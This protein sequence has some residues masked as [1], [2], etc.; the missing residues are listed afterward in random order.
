[1]SKMP[2]STRDYLRIVFRRKWWLVVFS[3]L[4][5]GAAAVA[6]T[7]MPSTY[8]ATSL[9]RRTDSMRN[10]RGLVSQGTRLSTDA[11]RREILTWDN[12]NGVITACNLDTALRTQAQWE[13]MRKKLEG[14]ISMKNVAHS[15]TVDHIEISVQYENPDMAARLANAVADRYVESSTAADTEASRQD[16]EFFEEET[17]KA[18]VRLQ[19]AEKALEEYQINYDQWV[20]LPQVKEGLNQR[21]LNLRI[22]KMSQEQELDETKKSLEAVVE[23]LAETPER[24]EGDLV[25][26]INPEYADM[27][28]RLNQ[29]ELQLSRM[30]MKMTDEHIEVIKLQDQIALLKEQL[31]NTPEYKDQP[32]G[33]ILNPVYAE[34]QTERLRLEQKVRQHTAAI[35]TIDAQMAAAEAELRTARDQERTYNDLVREKAEASEQYNEFRVRRDQARTRLQLISEKELGTDVEIISRAIPPVRPYQVPKMQMALLL[36]V[37][38]LAMGGG[39][40][41]GLEFLDESF[42]SKEDAAEFLQIAVLGSVSTIDFDGK[43]PQPSGQALPRPGQ[44]KR[45]FLVVVLLLVLGAIGLGIWELVEPGA[46]KEFPGHVQRLPGRALTFVRQ[47]VGRILPD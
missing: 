32:P 4:G 35:A 6:F 34:R 40:V 12:L 5:L 19:K 15:G 44:A 45:V 3:I 42:R 13:A 1:M 37:A 27:L 39:T 23:Q 9:V 33:E 20:D 43:P 29:S 21:L 18:R 25:R 26:V 30:R 14:A 16:M 8:L 38:G 11:L 47:L 28:R 46:F 7:T 10:A 17:D 41:V 36:M 31:A 24:V 2:K 22:R